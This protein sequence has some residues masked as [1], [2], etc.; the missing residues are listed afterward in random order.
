MIGKTRWT[1]SNLDNR[2]LE[3]A[4]GL[5]LLLVGVV[6]VVLP[7]LGVTGLLAPIRTREIELD[8]LTRVPDVASAGGVTLRGTRTAELV[9][10]DPDL[11]ERL[12]L[13]LP[14]LV[15][16]LLLL[17]ILELLRRMARTLRE[18]EVFVAR[19]AR[20]LAVIALAVLVLGTVVPVVDA[21]TTH[22]LAGGT[23]LGV[24]IPFSYTISGFYLLLSVLIAAAGEAFRQGTRLRADTEGLV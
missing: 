9:F 19:N 10:V 20:R 3:A 23:D 7:I 11:A 15:R 5:A 21:V 24:T 22:L 6:G 16:T 2:V 12:L 17:V 18:G 4:L 1:W 13:V 8:D 14:D